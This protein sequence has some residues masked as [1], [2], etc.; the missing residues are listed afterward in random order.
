MDTESIHIL[1]SGKKRRNDQT[2]KRI[3]GKSYA[4]RK[5]NNTIQEIPTPLLEPTCKCKY[6]CKNISWEWKLKLF[7]DY[8]RLANDSEQGT[9]I[10]GL[11]QVTE[12]NRRRHGQYS[13]PSH[14]HKQCTIKYT[15]P[16]DEGGVSQVCKTT[17]QNIL[18][19]KHRFLQTLQSKKKQ[20]LSVYKDAR[21]GNPK[22]KSFSNENRQ[23]IIDHINS[24][25]RNASHYGRYKSK[26]EY[27]SPDLNYS[28]LFPYI[29]EG[30]KYKKCI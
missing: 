13:H 25:P 9:Y 5:S 17:F 28:R 23:Q 6:E 21:L 20:G 10:L 29:W 16:N 11:I 7:N 22:R 26:K 15:I 14:S 2:K 12:I 18:G 4:T 30:F 3:S 1:R 24:F 8:H 27:L 19:V